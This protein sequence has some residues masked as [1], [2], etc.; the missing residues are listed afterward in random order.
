MDDLVNFAYE[1]REVRTFMRDGEPWWV[2]KDVAEVL[3]YASSNMVQIFSHV[4][5]EWK[6]SNPIAT[7]SGVQNMLCLSEPGLYFFLGRSNKP[8]ASPFQKWIAGEVIPS[9]R[10][11]GS[12]SLPGAIPPQAMTPQIAGGINIRV[13]S[14]DYNLMDALWLYSIGIASRKDLVRFRL[15]AA[16]EPSENELRV[17]P[18]CLWWARQISALRQLRTLPD[19]DFPLTGT[20]LEGIILSGKKGMKGI[21]VKNCSYG[22]PYE[23]DRAYSR[24]ASFFLADQFFEQYERKTEQEEFRRFEPVKKI[25]DQLKSNYQYADHTETRPLYLWPSKSHKEIEELRFMFDSGVYSVERV[26]AA[27]FGEQTGGEALPGP[28]PLGITDR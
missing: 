20:N 18:L 21:L 16:V 4:P 3:G 12:Y 22:S 11:T 19:T 27:L 6:G 5:G 8:T 9:I 1:G 23:K 26:R 2:G 28:R 25:Y 15:G 10:R 14:H 13:I 24:E 7:P 17:D